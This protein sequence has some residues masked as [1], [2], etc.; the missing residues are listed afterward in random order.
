MEWLTQGGTP[1]ALG[2]PATLIMEDE[3]KVSGQHRGQWEGDG[4]LPPPRLELM[5]VA[6]GNPV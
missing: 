4:E 6:Q 5:Q 3:G 2:W 1:S